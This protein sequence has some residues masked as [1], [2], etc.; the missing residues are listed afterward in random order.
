MRRGCLA[1]LARGRELGCRLDHPGD[2]QRQRQPGQP[3]GPARQ[4]PVEAELLG[5][6]E[7]RRDMAVRQGAL[8]RQPLRRRHHGL[9]LEDP[10]QRFDLG[11]RPAREIGERAR[12][13]LAVIAIAL[14]QEDRRR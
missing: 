9:A 10:A 4:Q 12:L 1:Q 11:R 14:A 5:H 13:D 3:L 6:A 8:D 2:D 7:H